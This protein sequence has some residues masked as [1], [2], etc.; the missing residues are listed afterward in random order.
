MERFNDIN[1]CIDCIDK[2]CG[3]I[4]G[5]ECQKC[6]DYLSIKNEFLS[7]KS[8]LEFTRNYIH[9]NGLEWDLLSKYSKTR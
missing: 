1:P 3:L 9:D 7:I 6:L 8:E 5:Q 4:D 2:E